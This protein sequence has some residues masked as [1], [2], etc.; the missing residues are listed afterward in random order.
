MRNR[1]PFAATLLAC[2]VA[3][4][5]AL[6]AET[7][8][9]QKSRIYSTRVIDSA[10]ILVTDR[11]QKQYTVHMAGRCVGLDP[12]AQYLSWRMKTELGCL[13]RGDTIGYSMPGEGTQPA[14]RPNLQSTCVVDSVTEGAPPEHSG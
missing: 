10:T 4:V 9:V 11:D 3:C 5:P 8:C 14:I 7:A 1:M 6:A 2:A 12:N 13:S